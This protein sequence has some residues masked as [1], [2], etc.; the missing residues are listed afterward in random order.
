LLTNDELFNKYRQNCLKEASAYN[1]QLICQ[2]ALA[3]TLNEKL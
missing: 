1:S 3:K 2:T